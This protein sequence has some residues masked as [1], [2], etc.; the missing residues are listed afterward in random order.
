MLRA[1]VVFNLSHAF[2]TSTNGTYKTANGRLIRLPYKARA[3]KATK[4]AN[5]VNVLRT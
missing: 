2:V 5:S 3:C 1:F 4:H